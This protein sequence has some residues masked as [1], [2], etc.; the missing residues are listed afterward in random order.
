MLISD[1]LCQKRCTECHSAWK[2]WPAV[3]RGVTVIET[4][5]DTF[6]DFIGPTQDAPA[7]PA[8]I[9]TAAPGE[10]TDEMKLMALWKPQYKDDPTDRL[11]NSLATSTCYRQCYIETEDGLLPYA[12]DFAFDDNKTNVFVQ[13]AK[14]LTWNA[15]QLQALQ[16]IRNAPGGLV[17]ILGIAGTGKTLLQQGL[18]RSF[19]QLRLHVLCLTPTNANADDFAL[20][21]SAAAPNTEHGRLYPVRADRPAV[22]MVTGGGEF[23]PQPLKDRLLEYDI[24]L[25]KYQAANNHHAS[26]RA[27]GFQAKVIKQA[28]S[29]TNIGKLIMRYPVK[30]KTRP[31]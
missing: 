22:G 25:A 20:K 1:C 7:E 28:L 4:P 8:P 12:P 3:P 5:T 6:L 11:L 21:L 10:T 24:A 31:G 19:D 15:E 13:F 2:W 9:V 17:C 27:L 29:G 30:S 18:A 14:L 16:L 23:G 26:A